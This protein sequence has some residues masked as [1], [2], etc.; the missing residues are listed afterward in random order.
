[1]KRAELA[2]VDKTTL[3]KYIK[4]QGLRLNQ[5]SEDM[6]YA[7]NYLADV[8]RE[9]RKNLPLPA[10]KHLCSML[11]VSEDKFIIKDEPKTVTKPQ[12]KT[13]TA[14]PTIINNGFTPEQFNALIQAIS[15]LGDT[16]NK[17]LEKI[18]STESSTA[19]IQGKIY[20]ELTGLSNAL[21][22]NNK[23]QTE[24]TKGVQ[25]RPQYANTIGGKH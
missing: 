16:I 7:S 1:M 14:T 13:E 5:L 15:N 18:A 8:L 2:F 19:I 24:V 21:G 17:G 20:G 22:V 3:K 10:Y 4:K 6:G 25:V 23:P 12:E 11:K 9:G